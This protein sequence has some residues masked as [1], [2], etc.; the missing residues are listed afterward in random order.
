VTDDLRSEAG[1]VGETKDVR[2]HLARDPQATGVRAR[3]AEDVLLSRDG[4]EEDVVREAAK[5]LDPVWMLEA[6]NPCQDLQRVLHATS[7]EAEERLAK[8]LHG[9]RFPGAAV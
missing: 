9:T 3:Q 7:F 8:C 1:F 5:R 4:E 2:L 6:S